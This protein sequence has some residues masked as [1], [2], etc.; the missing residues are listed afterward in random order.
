MAKDKNAAIENAEEVIERFGGIRPMSSKIDVP[1]TTIQ[2]WKKRNSIPAT[3][4]ALILEA[5]ETYNV[6]LDDLVGQK[7]SSPGNDNAAAVQAG[8]QKDRTADA[9]DEAE[10]VVLTQSAEGQSETALSSQSGS[11]TVPKAL[12]PRADDDFEAKLAEVE[13]RAVTKSTWITIGLLSVVTLIF[14]GLLFS[15]AEIK[16][17][18]VDE[19]RLG[20][21]ENDVDGLQG[22]VAALQEK[23][24]FFEGMVPSDLGERLSA[25]QEQATQARENLGVA[26]E[27]ARTISADV[28]A[29]NL[30][31]AERM[32]ALQAHMGE[33]SGRPEMVA[34]LDRFSDFQDTIPGQEYLSQSVAELSQAVAGIEDQNQIAEALSAAR[35]QS[36]ALNQTLEGVPQDDIKAA[37]MLLGMSQFRSS[38]NRDN[39]PFDDDLQ[40]LK[41]L[42]GQDN[43]ELSAAL[44]RLAPQAR[45]GVLTPAGLTSEFKAMTGEIVVDSLKGEDVS[46]Q[47]KAAAR[48]GELFRL[49]KDGQPI[50]GTET[51]AKVA[52][53]ERM[54]ESGDLEAA[55]AQVQSLDGPAAAA[56]Q[57]WLD[58]AQATVMAQKLKALLGQMMTAQALG[59]GGLQNLEAMPSDIQE[60]LPSRGKLI[61]NDET[62]INILTQPKQLNIPKSM[63]QP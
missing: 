51:Q 11:H 59:P 55:I 42:V 43:P 54:L 35:A 34:L 16:Q 29:E 23:Q 49:E 39:Q 6:N 50:T 26:V 30:T 48:F 37:V 8:A 18:P 4:R 10:P 27:A 57:P 2:G 46:I 17:E 25:L 47:E 40:L 36:A 53:A 52:Q 1:V 3:R 24:G 32:A 15:G 14:A 31:L 21:L 7:G 56:A 19:A 63:S 38:L 33:M 58:K 61:Q 41:N 5:A 62:G 20:A 44:D 9:K 12:Q 60:M 13:K 45:E 22:D 28:M